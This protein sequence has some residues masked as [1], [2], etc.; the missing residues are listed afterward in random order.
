METL[1]KAIASLL[2]EPALNPA[3]RKTARHLSLVTLYNLSGVDALQ[4]DVK[5]K[6]LALIARMAAIGKPVYLSQ[7]FRSAK[8]QDDKYA[9]G[10]TTNGDVVTNARGLQSYHQYGLAFDLIFVDHNWNAPPSWWE[11]L[12][13]E[14]QALGL[15]WGGS[16]TGFQD[17]PHFEYHPGFDWKLLESYFKK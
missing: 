12:G 17:L 13:K 5:Q 4:D 11:I 9:Q 6:C 3:V 14:G 15:E 8:E 10:R 2:N 1:F 7:G 16:W